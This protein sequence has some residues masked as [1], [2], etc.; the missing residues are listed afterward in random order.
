[1][2]NGWNFKAIYRVSLEGGVPEQLTSEGGDLEVNPTWSPDGT[3]IDFS[4]SPTPG[5]FTG[6]KVLDLAS[7]KVSVWPGTPGI[8]LPSWSP[9][10]KFMVAIAES[11]KRMVSILEKRKPGEP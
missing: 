7:K 6:I 1:M 2:V 11:P 9:D 10:R 4:G 5:H 8:Y 3:S